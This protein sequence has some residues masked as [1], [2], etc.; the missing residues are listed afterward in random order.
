M[1]H[2]TNA[3]YQRHIT[4]KERPCRP[5]KDAHAAYMDSYHRKTAQAALTLPQ[6]AVDTVALALELGG[7][8]STQ[9]LRWAAVIALRTAA[10]VLDAESS[11]LHG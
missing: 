4:T 10:A 7:R 11:G 6:E 3:G 9:S 5:C 8:V 2:G 1:G